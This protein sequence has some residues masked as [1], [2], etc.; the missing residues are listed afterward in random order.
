MA[1]VL[2]FSDIHYESR[3]HGGVDQR[4]AWRWLL[5]M[6]E[7]H[8][9]DAVL[10]AGDMGMAVN[11]WR[12]KELASRLMLLAIYGNHDNLTVL[13]RVRN[14][15]GHPV[16]MEDGVVYEVG[17]LRIAGI[18][19]IVSGR[20]MKAGVPRRSV[21]EIIEAARMLEDKRIDILLIHQTPYLPRLFD[22]RQD[23][24]S[25]A[26]LEAIR[27]VKPRIVVN[28]HIH[29][30]GFNMLQLPWGTLYV[31]IDSSQEQRHYLKIEE[32]E[33]RFIMEVWRDKNM[34]ERLEV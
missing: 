30:G 29:R 17:G 22:M 7:Y 13:R 11:L 20:R 26:A 21:E 3:P 23:P 6:V 4:M 19:G 9:P 1:R 33:G 16:L 15:S 8:K 18:N 24:G 32:A 34:V 31:N 12:L 10:S 14:A 5:D 27:I 28:G 25:E 2:A